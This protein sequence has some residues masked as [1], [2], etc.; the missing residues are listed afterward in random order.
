MIRAVIFDMDGVI[1]D[2]TPYTWEARN[3]YLKKY[4][5]Y[6]SDKEIS[7]LLGRSLRD[8]LKIIND[9]HN[10]NLEFNDFSRK[11]RK[12]QV[13]LMKKNLKPCKGVKEL[14]DDLLKHNI[15]IGLASSNL[16]RNILEDLKIMGLLDKF[17]IITSVEE[18]EHHKPHPE[19]FLKTAEKLNVRPEECVVIE[20]AINGIEAAKN[21]NMKAIA[22]LTRFHTKEDF[23]TADLIVNSLEE[24]DAKK[25]ATLNS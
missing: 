22:V 19:I 20:D 9:K 6:I 8:Q 21:G 24:L 14:I 23:K 3:I 12:I 5:V 25:I 16:K 17:K 4:G 15:K 10:L 11:T 13:K 7:Q 1:Y 2:S 18:A